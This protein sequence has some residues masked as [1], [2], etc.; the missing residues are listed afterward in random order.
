[1]YEQL[2]HSLHC[3]KNY[4]NI[5]LTDYACVAAACCTQQQQNFQQTTWQVYI[6]YC[7][8]RREIFHQHEHSFVQ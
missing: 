6:K 4:L 7:E 2:K 3:M 8:R 1:M 5:K